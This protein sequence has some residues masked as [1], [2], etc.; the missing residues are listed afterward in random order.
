VGEIG[1]C[2]GKNNSN[3]NSNSKS[4][5]FE[6]K[7]ILFHKLSVIK[8]NFKVNKLGKQQTL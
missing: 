3:S 6:L 1:Q 8:K 2:T 4:F 5:I 7:N